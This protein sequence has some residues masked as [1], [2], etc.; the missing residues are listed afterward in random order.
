MIL[1]SLLVFINDYRFFLNMFLVI[2]DNILLGGL[3]FF[4]NYIWV[5]IW[6]VSF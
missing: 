5:I 1:V 2:L 6:V 4:R 3:I